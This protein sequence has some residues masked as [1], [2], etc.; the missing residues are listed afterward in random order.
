MDERQQQIQV[1]AGLQESRLN[2]ELI[3]FLEKWGT[4]ILTVI[5]VLVAGYVGL[6]KWREYQAARLDDAFEQYAAARGKPA[7]DGVLDGSPDNLLKV[8]AEHASRGAVPHL[9]RLDAAEILLASARRGLKPGS[10]LAAPKPEDVLAPDAANDLIT[11]AAELFS[12]VRASV[13]SDPAASVLALR[14]RWGLAA[15]ALSTGDLEAA[16]THYTEIGSLARTAGL[17]EQADL[18]QRRLTTLDA[19]ATPATLY[20]DKDLPVI[21]AAPL[22]LPPGNTG[23]PITIDN[24]DGL[25]IE[26]MPEGFTPPGFD[27][28]SLPTPARTEPQGETFTIPPAEKPAEKPVEEPKKP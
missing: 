7:A 6:N 12:Q 24:P 8:A 1:G 16:R 2:T 11:R 13:G 27:P 15:T 20:S 9:A 21:A 17:T 3:A 26:R 23:I 22:T 28:A 19:Y 10:D 5:L 25:K 14:S 4:W 18:A